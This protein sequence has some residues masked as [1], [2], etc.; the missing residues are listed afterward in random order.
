[1]GMGRAECTDSAI[2]QSTNKS[3]MPGMGARKAIGEN[4]SR[5]IK[6][7][8]LYVSTGLKYRSDGAQGGSTLPYCNFNMPKISQTWIH[9]VD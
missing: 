2:L 3:T 1:M 4:S 9:L 6:V 8:Y 5:V 7:P